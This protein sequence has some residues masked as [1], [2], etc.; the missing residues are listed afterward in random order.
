MKE[1]Y[2]I[3]EVAELLNISQQ[4]LRFYDKNGI[5]VPYRTDPKTGYRYY[6]YDQLCYISR[7]K[8]LQQFGFNLGEIREALASNDTRRLRVFLREKRRSLKAEVEKL[9]GL[10]EDLDWYIDY[11]GYLEEHDYYGLPY[12]QT[13]GERFLLAEPLRPGEDIYGSVGKRLTR[14]QHSAEF[15]DARFLRCHGYILDF[16]AL[17]EGRLVPTHY[18]IYLRQKPPRECARVITVPAGEY[19]CVQSRVL[20]EPFDGGSLRPYFKD[21]K[22]PRIVLAN[23]YE[24][25]FTSFKNCV[26]EI[27][28]P[29]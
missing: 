21:A 4:T 24:D 15:V 16:S 22:K 27:Q 5:V 29:I 13:E 19:L 2:T 9:S 17:L 3:G 20:A 6:S 10:I 26:Y 12:C 11:Y 28:I 23:E 25:N 1:N 14:V 18:F 7:V 8:Y